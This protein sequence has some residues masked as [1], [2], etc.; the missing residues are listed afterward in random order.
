MPATRPSALLA[1]QAALLIALTILLIQPQGVPDPLSV[2]ADMSWTILCLLA[3]LPT[4][5]VVVRHL[6]LPRTTVDPFL[7][8]YLACYIVVLPFSQGRHTSIVWLL[9]LLSDLLVFYAVVVA[10]RSS[11]WAVSTML[12][13]IVLGTAVLEI[14]A[15]QYHLEHGLFTRFSEYDRPEGWSGYP[16]LGFMACVQ[17]AILIAMLHDAHGWAR[18]AAIVGVAAVCGIEIVFLFSRAAWVIAAALLLVAGVYGRPVRRMWRPV[19]MTGLATLALGG[20]ISVTMTGRNLLVSLTR[21]AASAGRLTLWER[22]AQM[23]GDHPMAGVG[24]GNFQAIFEPVYNPL[25]NNDVRRGGHAHNLWLQ[26]AAE[27]GLIAGAAYLVLW[28]AI[29]RRAAIQ[30]TRSWVQRAAFLVLMSVALRSVGD[31][32]FFSTGGAPGRLYTLV[33][34]F[35]G[36]VGAGVT[37]DSND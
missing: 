2:G 6:R 8:G 26:Q 29:L 35:W 28:L 25:L 22:T 7:W 36:I 33:W 10:V 17:L 23:I 37:P 14:I 32:M 15:L 31:Y 4:L 21:R 11:A 34:I 16:E 1:I 13:L 12:L 3:A 9:A 18:R 24:A 27:V 19:L 20:M 30:G 5:F